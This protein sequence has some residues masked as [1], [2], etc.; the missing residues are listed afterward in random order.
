MHCTNRALSIYQNTKFE[1]PSRRLFEGTFCGF[2]LKD[3]H[4]AVFRH[5]DLENLYLGF[6][7]HLT[8]PLEFAVEWFVFSKFKN[9]QRIF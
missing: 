1:F 6:Q 2:S 9:F 8:F 7:F 3:D 4:L 5:T